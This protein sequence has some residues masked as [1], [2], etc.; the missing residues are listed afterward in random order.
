M[1]FLKF[2][3]KVKHKFLLLIS[4]FTINLM[5]KETEINNFYKLNKNLRKFLSNDIVS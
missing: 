1:I 2:S 5:I 3:G 4:I